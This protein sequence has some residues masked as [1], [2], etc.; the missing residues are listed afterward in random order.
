MKYLKSVSVDKKKFVVTNSNV[1][2]EVAR[3]P[4]IHSSVTLSE[5]IVQS[6]FEFTSNKKTK[7]PL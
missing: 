2:T 1:R 4:M 7:A 6:T 3:D 5:L